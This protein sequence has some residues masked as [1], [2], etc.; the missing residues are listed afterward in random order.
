[1]S[2][3]LT[4]QSTHTACK[5]VVL[6]EG[7]VG[8]SALIMRL[9][10][11]PP[12]LT[13]EHASDPP[14]DFAYRKRMHADGHEMLLDIMDTRSREHL[15]VYPTPRDDGISQ[16]DAALLVFSLTS[17]ASFEAVAATFQDIQRTRGKRS[18]FP[19]AAAMPL[20]VCANKADLYTRRAVS[21]EQGARFARSIDAPYFE[22]SA[23]TRQNLE[24]AFV[25]CVREHT[26]LE[27]ERRV[28][29]EAELRRCVFV[30]CALGASELPVEIVVAVD[31]L[32]EWRGAI[33]VEA[34]QPKRFKHGRRKTKCALQ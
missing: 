19:A 11:H 3:P 31:G 34:L 33:D 18:G 16:G 27:R 14:M 21:E 13:S 15:P 2:H 32:I 1:M 30:W 23:A 5:V 22:T 28:R 24:E 29:R 25:A 12:V 17:V 20:V 6:G 4:V 9:C 7:G 10:A 8:K 26:R